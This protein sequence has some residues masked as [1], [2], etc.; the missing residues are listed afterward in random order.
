MCDVLPTF[1]FGLLVSRSEGGGR[2][3]HIDAPVAVATNYV[4]IL[5]DEPN[6]VTGLSHLSALSL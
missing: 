3:V 6:S 2:D 4:A 1:P 5:I